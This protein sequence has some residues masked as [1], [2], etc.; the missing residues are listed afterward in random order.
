MKDRSPVFQRQVKAFSDEFEGVPH[1][2]VGHALLIHWKVLRSI[3]M[4]RGT[5]FG[6]NGQVA[7]ER[8]GMRATH[9][10]EHAALRTK[11]IDCRLVIRQPQI[12]EFNAADGS[13]TAAH[14]DRHL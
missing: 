8:R 5:A 2:L 1:G 6:K 3:S 11:R 12:G 7:A 4:P 14:V 9:A 10:F 13:S